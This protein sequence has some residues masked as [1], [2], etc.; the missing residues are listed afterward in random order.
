MKSTHSDKLERW[1]GVEAT[2]RLSNQFKD[3]Y[4]PVRVN[5][6]PGNVFIMPGGGFAGEIAVGNFMSAQDAAALTI[7][8]IKARLDAKAKFNNAT[9]NL[10]QLIEIGDRRLLSVGAFSTIDSVIAAY[11]GG[12]A[13]QLAFNKTGVASNAIGNVND[14]WTRAGQPAAGAAGAAAPG[15]SVPTATTTGALGYGNLGVVANGGH[16]L[17]W[18]LSSSVIGNS[19]LLYDRL[20]SVAK[21][22]NSTTAETVTGVPTRYQSGTSGNVDYIG[23]NF[24]FPANPTTVLAATAHNWTFN[25]NNQASAAK[26]S[27]TQAGV[28]AG[29]VGG[30]DLSVGNWFIP[31]A[32]GDV[33]VKAITSMTCSALVATGTIDFVIGH[34]LAANACPLANLACLDDGL[35]TANLI[36]I[37]D[38][39]CLSFLE[40]PKPTT[41]ATNYSG[42]VRTVSE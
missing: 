34:A 21:T 9:K 19:L 42:I 7:K 6:V 16:Y 26:T 22:I 13:Q 14:L 36:N 2:Q 12:K 24:V 35:N 3:F 37:M 20:F 11:T 30:V 4:A 1:L 23:G 5:G 31:L 41:T 33:G 17:N 39:A 40:L 8:K 29:V 25:Y 27:A 28:S 32:A 18:V 38:N 10:I 15:G